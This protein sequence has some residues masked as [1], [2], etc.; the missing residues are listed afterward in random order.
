MA[1]GY[2]PCRHGAAGAARTCLA[3]GHPPLATFVWR[4]WLAWRGQA[5]PARWLLI[6]LVFAGS[7]GVIL[8]FR[9]LFGQ[10]PG[11]ALLI[12]FLA[13]K[14]LEART[15]RDGLAIVFLAYFLALAQFFYSQAIPAAIATAFGTLVATAAAQPGRPPVAGPRP[16]YVRPR[17][18]CCRPLPSCCC[19]LCCFPASRGHSGGC[20]RMPTAPSPDFPRP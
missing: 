20:P 8:Q 5:L 14:Q 12:L 1:A 11:V 7:G 18:C 4:G 9:T 6:L 10:N 19:Y 2:R 3:D 13:L 17:R 16:S 15:A